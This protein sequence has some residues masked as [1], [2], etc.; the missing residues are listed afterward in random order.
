MLNFKFGNGSIVE[1][2][3]VITIIYNNLKLIQT[4]DITLYYSTMPSTILF[5]LNKYTVY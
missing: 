2:N 3:K 5:N 4:V 1:I